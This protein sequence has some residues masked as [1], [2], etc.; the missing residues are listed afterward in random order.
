MSRSPGAFAEEPIG[1]DQT[2]F[3]RESNGK[4]SFR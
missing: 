1:V 3:E 4:L 2:G